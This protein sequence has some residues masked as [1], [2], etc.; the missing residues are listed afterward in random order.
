MLCAACLLPLLCVVLF[1]CAPLASF[2]VV[3]CVVF[4]GGRCLESCIDCR[5]RCSVLCVV[6]W[7]LLF[8]VACC[9]VCVVGV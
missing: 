5:C 8:V 4:A 1:V 7:L 2:V 6:C 3:R 9:T